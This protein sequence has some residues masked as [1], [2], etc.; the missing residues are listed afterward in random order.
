L[1]IDN[2]LSAKGSAL[3]QAAEEMKWLKCNDRVQNS[4]KIARQVH[5]EELAPA[6]KSKK[7]ELRKEFLQ[8]DH[9]PM[10]VYCV[11]CGYEHIGHSVCPQ[12]NQGHISFSNKFAES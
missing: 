5:V 8:D 9:H 7:L 4:L 12:S 3:I 6:I 10:K 11:F 2:L 1:P